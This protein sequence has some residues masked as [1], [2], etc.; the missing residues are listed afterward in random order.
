MEEEEQK[1]SET[2][3]LPNLRESIQELVELNKELIKEKKVKKFKIPWNARLSKKK[4]RDNYATVLY[5]NDNKEAEFYRAPISEG[6]ISI[7]GAPHLAQQ[8][9]IMTHKG[10]PFMI[11]PSWSTHPYSPEKEYDRAIKENRINVGNRLLLNAMERGVIK[12]GKKISWGLVI[13][14][15]VILGIVVYYVL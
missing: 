12:L 14:G 3:K 2:S 1:K 15:I 6:A 13:F 9:H 10:K 4:V 8:E 7:K 11:I 5:V